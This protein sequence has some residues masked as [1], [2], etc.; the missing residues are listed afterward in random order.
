MGLNFASVS[1]TKSLAFPCLLN[2]VSFVARQNL[3]FLFT[4]ITPEQMVYMWNV[5]TAIFTV[6]CLMIVSYC[7]ALASFPEHYWTCTLCFGIPFA[8]IC[9]Q[10]ILGIFFGKKRMFLLLESFCC[11]FFPKDVSS[12]GSSEDCWRI[13]HQTYPTHIHHT[14][15]IPHI[16]VQNVSH[17][18]VS[19]QD[20][21]VQHV[22]HQYVSIQCVSI[23]MVC[24]SR[25]CSHIHSKRIPPIRIHA[26]RIHSMRIHSKGVHQQE[27]QT[28]PTN[29]YPTNTYPFNTYPTS[30]DPF[31]AYPCTKFA[32]AGMAM[33]MSIIACHF[34]PL[35]L[36]GNGTENRNLAFPSISLQLY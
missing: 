10:Q 4:K 30:T 16:S 28:Y 17:Q 29:T 12:Q 18:Y 35:L 13:S 21:S 34:I 9:I 24:I 26:M 8:Y 19:H 22:S 2:P 27:S 33:S 14:T 32:S 3:A 7:L 20:V 5:L 23:Q 36:G 6:Q 25:F 15:H 11:C 31:N 1:P